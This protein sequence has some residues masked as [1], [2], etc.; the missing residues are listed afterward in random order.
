VCV[1]FFL[2]FSSSDPTN[3]SDSVGFVLDIRLL[4]V[5]KVDLIHPMTTLHC[6]NI[7]IGWVFD[8]VLVSRFDDVACSL[9]VS[10]PPVVEILPVRF[11]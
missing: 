7:E 9:I 6:S 11:G 8:V 2:F 3:I 5:D 10:S 1:W 4:I